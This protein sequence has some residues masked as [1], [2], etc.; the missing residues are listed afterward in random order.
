MAFNGINGIL[1]TG[2]GKSASRW[3]Q[4]RNQDL[5]SPDQRKKKIRTAFLQKFFHY[6]TFSY[7]RFSRSKHCSWVVNLN[8]FPTERIGCSAL[9]SD[10]QPLPLPSG[11]SD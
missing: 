10:L 4:G 2:G 3:K 7:I 9:T 8:T 6:F 5:V 1:R 11:F